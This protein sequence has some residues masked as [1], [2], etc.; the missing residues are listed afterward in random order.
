MASILAEIDDALEW[1]NIQRAREDKVFFGHYCFKD[2]RGDAWIMGDL[3]REWQDFM[4]DRGPWQGVIAGARE[5]QKTSQMGLNRVIWEMGNDPAIRAKYVTCN[6]KKAKDK[7]RW[8]KE[9]IEGNPR[10]HAVFPDL[11]PDR[12]AGWGAT[13][14]MVKRP[15][16]RASD[17][18]L[19]VAGIL[20]G[21]SGGRADLL[22]FDDI[23]DFKT[24]IMQPRMHEAIAEY[25]REVWMN[26]AARW[27]RVLLI[28]I[29]TTSSDI[30]SQF[31]ADPAWKH[32]TKAAIDDD[33]NATYPQY[34]PLDRLM[35]RR[36]AIGERAFLRQ[37]MLQAINPDERYFSDEI[38]RMCM[39]DWD[40]GAHA[41]AD[42]PRYGGVDMAQSARR[43]ASYSV[44]FTIAVNPATGRRHPVEIV[45]AKMQPLE[46]KNEVISA[47]RRHH[48]VKGKV[49]NNGMQEILVQWIG[50][51]AKDV[52]I[53][54]FYTGN[55]KFDP[56]VGLPR[57]ITQMA[58]CGWVIPISAEHRKIVAPTYQ[59][60]DEE[61][62]TA[63]CPV[64]AWKLEMEK[65]PTA[66]TTDTLM[67]MW[68]ADAAAASGAPP[69]QLLSAVSAERRQM[70]TGWRLPRS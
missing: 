48:W 49:E 30:L 69:S 27:A 37:F 31:L 54:G 15:P 21:A 5:F 16:G 64:C 8:V 11:K 43:K 13:Q 53:E 70:P 59:Q 65:F 4:P 40:I 6:D 38:I 63:H 33:G 2:E 52:P 26:V 68:L 25:F 61:A 46:L 39:E 36:G 28:G 55:N 42:W 41:H 57:L 20:S 34:W 45:R 3:H 44:I 67:A 47:A 12:K 22:V 66:R 58:Q 35:E 9:N 50:E 1:H 51:E 17:A 56:E 60:L 18:S 24:V 19:E 29:P 23:V 62:D 32:F 14:I 10:L 7:L